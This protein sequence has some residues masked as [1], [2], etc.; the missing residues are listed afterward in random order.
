MVS[1]VERDI[2]K[3]IVLDRHTASNFSLGFVNG[4]GLKSGAV[5]GSIGHDS[6]NVFSVGTNDEDMLQ[7][8]EEV[9]RMNG[10]IVLVDRGSVVSRLPLPIAGLMS[11]DDL[12]TVVCRIRDLDSK[13]ESYGTN[14]ELLMAIFFV[15]LAVIPKIKITD[16]GIVDVDSQRFVSLF[17]D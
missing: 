3:I 12:E 7:A 4:F 8:V 17:V 6:H 11:N 9:R 1:D 2:L 10:G 14:K 16:R 15:Q 13:L 5:A